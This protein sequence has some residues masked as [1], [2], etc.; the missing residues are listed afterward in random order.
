MRPPS[1]TA[2]R[3]ERARRRSRACESEPPSTFGRFLHN[4]CKPSKAKN[5]SMQMSDFRFQRSVSTVPARQKAN[6]RM[7]ISEFISQLGNCAREFLELEQNQNS[8]FRFQGACLGATHGVDFSDFSLADFGPNLESTMARPEIIIF[9]VFRLTT[10]L[11]DLTM[12]S[13]A[14]GTP[15]LSWS[16]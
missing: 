16:L 7:Q 12:P 4:F 14:L 10:G 13:C 2:P 3:R 1:A 6:S 9:T 15:D 11:S 5:S 8:K